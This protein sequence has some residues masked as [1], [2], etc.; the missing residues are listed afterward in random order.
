MNERRHPMSDADRKWMRRNGI[1]FP[2]NWKEMPPRSGST[3]YILDILLYE[4]F[5]ITD[6]DFSHFDGLQILDIGAGS[7][8]NRAQAQPTFARTCA[9]N[10]ARVVVTDILP[11]SEPDAR[12]FDGVVTGDLITP[13]LQGRFA[14][15][16]EFAGRTFDIIHSSGLINFIPDPMFSN[17]LDALGIKEDSFARLLTEQAGSMLVKNGVMYLGGYLYR[18]I[19]NELKL[20]KSFD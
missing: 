10:G 7:H 6:L 16:P 19:D 12:L 18:K 5:G 9:G 13:V 11:Q 4:L 14:Q 8:L 20:T 1:T 2:H 15:L 3:G 17:T